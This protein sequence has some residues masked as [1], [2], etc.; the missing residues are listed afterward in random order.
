MATGAEVIVSDV[1]RRI[2]AELPALTPEM[3]G[4]FVEVIPEFR[5]DDAV[6]RLMVAST[7]SN[8]GVI[9]DMLALSIS[10]DDIT[11]PPAAAEYARRFAQHDLSLVALLRAYR[12]G[13]HMFL[14]W[15]LRVLGDLDL[16]ADD[17]LA[18]AGRV[19]LLV[20]SYID[21]VIEGVIDIYETE[22]RQWDGRSD[23][24]RAAQVRVV[25]DTEGLDVASA[26][27][28]LA[29]SLRG[30]HVAAVAWVDAPGLDGGP[31]LR[32]A[33]WLLSEAAGR[34]PMTMLADGQTLWAW[35]SSTRRPNLDLGELARRLRDHPAVRI[36]LGEP[37]TGLA[38]FRR[39]H[40][41]ALRARTVAE[42]GADAGRQLH[43]HSRIALSGLLVEQLGDVRVWVCRILG[44]LIRDDEAMARLRETVR[45]FLDTGGS[46]T[47]AAARMHVHKNTVHYR[48]RKAEEILGRPL[49]EGRL[50]IE[51]AL[52]ACDQLGLASAGR[53]AESSRSG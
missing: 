52:L 1:A 51:V 2:A 18:A 31:Y 49:G 20:N 5:H 21:Q 33:G 28:M 46:Y 40:R 9:V 7:S 30:W 4:M 38:G 8:L 27:E 42:I 15:A 53:P 22:R 19:A 13:E 16:P 44:D 37:A 26:E 50:A 45:I 25:L 24:A 47:D 17:T 29:I 35:M 23:A 34:M 6:Q 39:S 11:V 41:E 14:Q 36:A 10:L 43:D 12:L 32:T 3:T 48:V